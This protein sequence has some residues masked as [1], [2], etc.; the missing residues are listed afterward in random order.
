VRADILTACALV[1]RDAA[2]QLC[3]AALAGEPEP[4]QVAALL[5]TVD[6]GLP[7]STDATTRVTALVPLERHGFGGLWER[8]PL[9]A[10]TEGLH[11]RGEVD[12]AID[13]VASALRRATALRLEG[14]ED[15]RAAIAE[16]R[17]AAESLALRSRTAPVRLLPGLLPLV[18]DPTAAADVMPMLRTWCQP[19]P[20]AVPALLGIA[21]GGGRSADEALAALVCLGAPEATGLLARHL[22]E[23]PRALEAAYRLATGEARTPNDSPPPGE[24]RTPLPFNP[25]LLGAIRVQLAA[26]APRERGSVFDGGLAATNEP[27]RLCGLLAAWGRSARAALPE[28]LAALPRHPLPVSRALAAVADPQVDAHAVVA[29]RAQAGVGPL[30]RVR[31]RR[32][33]ST[34]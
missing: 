27:V 24:D 10:L 2:E 6:C 12:A 19:A 22:P 31:P 16:A 18:D 8:E 25:E 11:E 1:D 17:W 14:S 30:G 4:V 34:P 32:A 13:V 15:A 3:P 9:R 29:L 28:L 20:E 23:R 26:G 5:A 7:W 33:R 21:R